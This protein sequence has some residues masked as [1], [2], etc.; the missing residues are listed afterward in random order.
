MGTSELMAVQLGQRAEGLRVLAKMVEDEES[1]D[2]ILKWAADYEWSQRALLN[3]VRSLVAVSEGQN[4]LN[5]REP[6]QHLSE[7]TDQYRALIRRFQRLVNEMEAW[8]GAFE[9]EC[10]FIKEL[11]RIT[12][13]RFAQSR[14]Y[15]TAI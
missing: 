4:Q 15:L 3:W 13:W 11:E 10:E 12:R 5:A 9:E 2:A 8:R 1:R 14:P 7:N 6:G